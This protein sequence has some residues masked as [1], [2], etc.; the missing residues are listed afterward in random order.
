MS[1][2]VTTT[3]ALHNVPK[4]SVNGDNFLIRFTQ[5]VKSKGVW[6]YLESSAT[7]PQPPATA[8]GVSGAS[9]AAPA[10][11]GPA[12]SLGT[13]PVDPT[14]AIYEADLEK[15][16]KDEA[17]ALD[18]LTQCILDSTVIHT[19]TLKTASAMW[20]EIVCEY[21]EKGTMTQT[22]LCTKLL[23]SRCFEKSDVHAFLDSLHVKREELVQA[24][25]DINEKD[26][27]STIIKSLPFHL[28][29]FAS[30]LT[31]FSC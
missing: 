17:L 8:T 29:N 10:I 18:L 22:D 3:T 13:P 25:V 4:L 11:Q 7:C 23:E 2:S 1:T 9:S 27:H 6:P 12:T 20:A 5:A 15:W 28:S 14:V 16:E 26:Y 19:S 31:A 24:G 21:T 30:L